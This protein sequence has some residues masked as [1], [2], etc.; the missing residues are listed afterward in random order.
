MKNIYTTSVCLAVL[1]A[2]SIAFGQSPYD[3][4]DKKQKERHV[5]SLPEMV[6][7]ADVEDTMSIVRYLELDIETL[8][9]K[10]FL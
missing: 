3:Q 10:C 4:F 2:Q 6:F 1:F 5:Y 8:L 9:L 7:R